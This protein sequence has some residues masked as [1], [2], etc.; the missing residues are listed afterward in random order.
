MAD[1]TRGGFAPSRSSPSCVAAWLTICGGRRGHDASRSTRGRTL[2]DPRG[3]A[4]KPRRLTNDECR[5]RESQRAIA[6][7]PSRQP[8]PRDHSFRAIAIIPFAPAVA[9]RSFVSRHRDHH[10]RAWQRAMIPLPIFQGA[11][12]RSLLGVAA[13]VDGL[14]TESVALAFQLRAVPKSAL[15]SRIRALTES[16]IAELELATDEALGRVEPE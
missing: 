3:G 6:I 15:S 4:S 16:E 5:R 7:I 8:W 10:L 12:G 11:M 13:T 2:D 9:T 14:P 1:D